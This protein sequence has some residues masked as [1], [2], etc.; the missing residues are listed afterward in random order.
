MP[1][2]TR[3]KRSAIGVV[4]VL[5]L[6]GLAACSAP[7]N[8]PADYDALTESN[9]MDGCTAESPP[10]ETTS[11]GSGATQKYCQCAYNWF[12]DNVPYDTANPDVYAGATFKS[13]SSKLGDSPADMPEAIKNDL[14]T[15]C[16]T[17]ADPKT[18]PTTT[19]T[20]VGSEVDQATTTTSVAG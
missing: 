16:G 18:A 11:L 4:L 6:F 13:L 2:S 1:K 7:S 17:S 20:T 8:A 19:P 10:P 3:P 14:A 9:F 5:A 12:V 15:A